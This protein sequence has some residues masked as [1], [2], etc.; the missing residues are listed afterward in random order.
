MDPEHRHYLSRNEFYRVLDIL[1][2]QPLAAFYGGQA[3]HLFLNLR[4]VNFDVLLEHFPP[5]KKTIRT[6]EKLLLS[7]EKIREAQWTPFW[8]IVTA[9]GKRKYTVP[10]MST[11]ADGLLRIKAEMT[12]EMSLSPEGNAMKW[13]YDVVSTPETSTLAK[14]NAK[15]MG[16]FFEA[17]LRATFV[18]GL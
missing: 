11:D 4:E 12:I 14:G 18:E 17:K 13:I 15:D 16:G 3:T 9:K 7:R 5:E 10:E 8:Y 2:K 1:G 6:R